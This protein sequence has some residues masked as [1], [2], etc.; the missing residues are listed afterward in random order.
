MA[1]L[2]PSRRRSIIPGMLLWALQRI[3][4][5]WLC[6]IASATESVYS[7]PTLASVLLA[8]ARYSGTLRMLRA[9]LLMA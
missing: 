2:M 7:R 8:S 9:F 4:M 5:V 1:T 3:S 6:V